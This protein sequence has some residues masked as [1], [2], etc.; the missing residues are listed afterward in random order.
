[1]STPICRDPIGC[2]RDSYC[3]CG[4][5]SAMKDHD[6]DG[7]PTTAVRDVYNYEGKTPL[8]EVKWHPLGGVPPKQTPAGHHAHFDYE[9]KS[10]PWL[11]EPMMS[12]IK[13]HDMRDM[14]DRPYKVG[15]R[16][17]LRE[18]DPR[19]GTYTGREG[20]AMITY[21]TNNETPCAMSSSVLNRDFAILSVTCHELGDTDRNA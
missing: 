3:S 2:S 16:M 10:W 18:F 11:F 4:N 19:T 14:R 9:V 17:L 12:G 6:A 21:I 8:P 15:D 5:E 7:L 1:M 13:Q 20:I